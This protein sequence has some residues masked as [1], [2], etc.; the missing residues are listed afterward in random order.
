L[1]SQRWQEDR[2]EDVAFSPDGQLILSA[3]A[4]KT[5]KLWDLENTS[6]PRSL[7]GHWHSVLAGAFSPDGNFIL[8]GGKDKRLIIWETDT[9]SIRWDSQTDRENGKFEGHSDEITDVAFPPMAVCFCQQQA[10]TR[11]SCY[12]ILR[13][14]SRLR[15]KH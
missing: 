12:G 14:T 7:E 11:Q 6:E 13:M 4:D 3:S 10:A 15:K 8:S 9:G 1:A 2:I 5:L